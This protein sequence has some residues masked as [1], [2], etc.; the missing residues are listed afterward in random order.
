MEGSRIA[1]IVKGAWVAKLFSGWDRGD[2]HRAARRIASPQLWDEILDLPGTWRH[3]LVRTISSLGHERN[4]TAG[5][6]AA[7]R[8]GHEAIPQWGRSDPNSVSAGHRGRLRL[9]PTGGVACCRAAQAGASQGG[10]PAAQA[11]A[12]LWRAPFLF[13]VTG[14]SE[15]PGVILVS[16]SR[17]RVVLL[18][19]HS[20]G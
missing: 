13:T 12:G 9:R 16:G 3:A 5:R 6:Y 14:R 11:R 2:R 18:R 15:R 7:G 20:L 10:R 19:R 1:G 4:A 17:Y 8:P